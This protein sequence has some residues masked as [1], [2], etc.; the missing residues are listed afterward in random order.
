MDLDWWFGSESLTG[1]I[2][3][4]IGCWFGNCAAGASLGY[5][6]E[7]YFEDDIYGPM[8]QGQNWQG[9]YENYQA[10]Q[11]GNQMVAGVDNTIL[12]GGI[13]LIVVLAK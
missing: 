7:G 4:G 2:A 8:N 10:W 9:A 5:S 6:I 13:L 11:S 12:I 1:E 3:T